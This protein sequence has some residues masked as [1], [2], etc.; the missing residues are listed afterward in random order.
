MNQSETLLTLK[1]ASK[2]QA[3]K[4][5]EKAEE[6]YNVK[7]LLILLKKARRE[8]FEKN[9]RIDHLNFLI[10][11]K[12]KSLS[13]PPAIDEARNNNDPKEPEFNCDETV[14]FFSR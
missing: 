13:V 14:F 2:V 12:E 4:V 6:C 8:I 9:Q 7:E 1:F 3:V 5:R 11:P 10:K